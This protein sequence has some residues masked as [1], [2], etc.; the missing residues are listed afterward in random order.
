MVF[1]TVLVFLLSVSSPTVESTSVS[2]ILSP[3]TTLT[4]RTRTL[5]TVP[6][7]SSDAHNS[8]PLWPD[9]HRTPSTLSVVASRCNLRSPK[10]SGS[11]RALLTASRRSSLMKEPPPFSR[12]LVPTLFVLLELLYGACSLLGN[13][14]SLRKPNV[15]TEL[16]LEFEL[17]TTY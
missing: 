1:T 15:R 2:S 4:K 16:H 10:K 14:C 9:T 13:Y 3:D 12:E 11:T 7:P 8:P 6:V 5:S 17:H